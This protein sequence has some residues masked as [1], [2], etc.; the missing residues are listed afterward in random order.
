[1][2]TAA[3]IKSAIRSKSGSERRIMSSLADVS[4]SLMSAKESSMMF[5]LEQQE[6]RTMYDTLYSGMELGQTIVGGIEQKKEIAQ[7][8]E[9]FK[10]ALPSDLKKDFR[11]EKTSLS[12]VLKG[13]KGSLTSYLTGKQ[14]YFIGDKSLGS[15]YDVS[16]RGDEIFSKRMAKNL[17]E[18]TEGESLMDRPTP[19]LQPMQAGYGTI[20]ISNINKMKPS[21][22][23]VNRD[24]ERFKYGEKEESQFG[25]VRYD[26][27]LPPVPQNILDLY[28]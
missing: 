1:M 9:R 12:D 24:V 5:D 3:Q 7:G 28:S 4:S 6:K 16:A 2:A 8:V 15:Q 27:D 21:T 19:T 22:M 13:K 11:M 23:Q 26:K 20:N 10:E 18:M 14:E 17:L 25:D